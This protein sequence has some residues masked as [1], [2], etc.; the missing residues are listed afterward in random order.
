MTRRI[1][2]RGY[3]LCFNVNT[4]LRWAEKGG[5]FI[6]YIRS[7]EDGKRTINLQRTRSATWPRTRHSH[8]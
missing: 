6:G 8:A 7:I 1:P 2:Y 5:R 4:G 3:V